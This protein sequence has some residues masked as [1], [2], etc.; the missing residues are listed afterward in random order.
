[1]GRTKTGYSFPFCQ[2][3]I[4]TPPHDKS[5]VFDAVMVIN[6][7]ITLATEFEI[8]PGVLGERIQHVVKKP[9]AGLDLGNP[10]S[11]EVET[12]GNIGLL[13]FPR[14]LGYSLFHNNDSKSDVCR[15]QVVLAAFNAPVRRWKA[16]SSPGQVIRKKS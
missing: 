2:C 15:L 6:I 14:E 3:L 10:R 9:D 8:K 16:F 5:T 1:M 12:T 13:G 7:E 4:K 11:V